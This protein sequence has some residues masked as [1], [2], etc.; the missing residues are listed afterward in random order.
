MPARRGGVLRSLV[1]GAI[2]PWLS[3]PGVRS[4]LSAVPALSMC[5]LITSNHPGSLQLRTAEL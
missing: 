1:F 5:V 3:E 4:L 2:V